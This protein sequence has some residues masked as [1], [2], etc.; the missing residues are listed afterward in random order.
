MMLPVAH[1][2]LLHLKIC[3][4]YFRNDH[5]TWSFESTSRHAPKLFYELIIVNAKNVN[6]SLSFVLVINNNWR[7]YCATVMSSNIIVNST[8]A[9]R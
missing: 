7:R 9:K 1:K 5:A 8:S 4:E 2:K 3:T 6:T